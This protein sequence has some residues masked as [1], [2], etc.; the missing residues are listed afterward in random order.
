V[1]K[2]AFLLASLL[3]AVTLVYGGLNLVELNMAGLLA[4]E[5]SDD[6]FSI[7]MDPQGAP[8]VTFAGRTARLHAGELCAELK[9]S[10]AKLQERYKAIFKQGQIL[11]K[12]PS[13]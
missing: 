2:L 9:Q 6:V 4:R 3:L 5:C 13:G 7:R 11:D 12:I 10:W 8:L 1:R